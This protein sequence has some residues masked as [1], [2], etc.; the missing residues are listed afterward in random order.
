MEDE[1]RE[2][3][4]KLLDKAGTTQ[5]RRLYFFIRKFLG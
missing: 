2:L 3:I 5:L 4:I 1:Y